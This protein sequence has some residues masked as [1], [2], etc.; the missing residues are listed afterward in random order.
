MPLTPKLAVPGPAALATFK[1][2]VPL[3]GVAAVGVKVTFAVAVSPGWIVTGSPVTANP[4]G[5]LPGETMASIRPSFF[6]LIGAGALVRPTGTLPRLAGFGFAEIAGTSTGPYAIDT[7]E[8]VWRCGKSYVPDVN[9]KYTIG[10]SWTST[11]LNF[12]S[13]LT[14]TVANHVP[15][16]PCLGVSCMLTWVAWP[17]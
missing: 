15:A 3:A 7:S 11:W 9:P 12:C 17:P 8:M 10:G 6:R 5:A 14:Y 4:A 2:T 13:P 16:A 1:F